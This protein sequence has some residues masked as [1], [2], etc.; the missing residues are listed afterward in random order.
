MSASLGISLCNS[1]V[2]RKVPAGPAAEEKRL[3]HLRSAVLVRN[4]N[5]APA[6]RIL[7]VDRMWR[8]LDE[9]VS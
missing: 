5:R 2:R 9:L 7:D 8:T 1:L 4:V 3:P 6:L